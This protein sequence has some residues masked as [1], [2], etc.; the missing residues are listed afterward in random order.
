MLSF[1]WTCHPRGARH[2]RG[3]VES[4]RSRCTRAATGMTVRSSRRDTTA[5]QGARGSNAARCS[6]GAQTHSSVRLRLCSSLPASLDTNS[7]PLVLPR[8]PRWSRAGS[9]LVTRG[10]DRRGPRRA[11]FRSTSPSEHTPQ[12]VSSSA[13]AQ[14]RA[15]RGLLAHGAAHRRACSRAACS[16]HRRM[17]RPVPPR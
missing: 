1:E 14:V 9:D 2:R 6:C 5:K 13:T 15:A 16:P 17:K 7:S 10:H 3:H 4:T 8:L 12:Q 11:Q